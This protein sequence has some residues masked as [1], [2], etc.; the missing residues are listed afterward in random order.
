MGEAGRKPSYPRPRANRAR[1][2][3]A[4]LLPVNGSYAFPSLVSP[5][6][7]EVACQRQD[8]RV[9]IN[10]PCLRPSPPC[11]ARRPPLRRKDKKK[12]YTAPLLRFCSSTKPRLDPRRTV[13]FLIQKTDRAWLHG[14]FYRIFSLRTRRSG[15]R[16]HRR[17]CFTSVS[18][19]RSPLTSTVLRNPSAVPA[20]MRSANMSAANAPFCSML[21]ARPS[22]R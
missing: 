7:G 3:L 10:T 18:V 22:A 6:Q 19:T 21:C 11:C 2:D 5:L 9:F 12:E 15:L 14:R 1:D 13:G 16:P 4:V 20:T 17:Y 8:E